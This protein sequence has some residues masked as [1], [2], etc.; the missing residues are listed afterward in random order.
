MRLTSIV[1]PALLA[2]SYPLTM[3]HDSFNVYL[4]RH[5]EKPANSGQ[6]LSAQGVERAQC[7]RKVFG[8][9]SS[10]DI[11]YIIAEQPDAGKF[12]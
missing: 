4:I 11:G 9:S 6:G 10:Y 1:L 2:T 5:G 8:A 12:T 3:A 7:L